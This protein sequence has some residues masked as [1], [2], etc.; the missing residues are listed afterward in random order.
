MDVRVILESGSIWHNKKSYLLGDTIVGLDDRIARRMIDGGQVEP[1]HVQEVSIDE[2]YP[3]AT[4]PESVPEM[5][6][7]EDDGEIEFAAFSEVDNETGEIMEP[8]IATEEELNTVNSAVTSIIDSI[9][10]KPKR[11]RP[12]K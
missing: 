6:F 9:V 11:G 10:E 2:V 7:V 5:V 3:E 1:L 8:V 4:L 12:K